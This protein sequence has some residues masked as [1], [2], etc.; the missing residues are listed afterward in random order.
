MSTDPKT[1]LAKSICHYYVD[2]AG[3]GTLFNARGK[4]IIGEE[5]C[6]RYFMLGILEVPILSI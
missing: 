3:D 5:G 2:E 4:V 6:S 1:D